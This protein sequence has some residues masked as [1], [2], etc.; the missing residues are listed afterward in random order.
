MSCKFEIFIGKNKQFYF[1]F[2]SSNGEIVL[3]SEGYETKESCQKG[4]ESVKKHAIEDKYYEK[5][6]VS[7]DKYMFNLK[8]VNG[9]V[10]GTSQSYIS[11]QTRQKGIESLKHNAVNAT[12]HDLS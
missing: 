5:K 8:A 6:K 11:E 3:A 1:H 7:N 9:K 10:I 12:I 4:I 2:K